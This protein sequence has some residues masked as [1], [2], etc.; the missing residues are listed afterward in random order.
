MPTKADHKFLAA[1]TGSSI[2]FTPVRGAKE[3][4]L[5]AEIYREHLVEPVQ[6]L[7]GQQQAPPRQT[8][9]KSHD[10]F[11]EKWNSCG[12]IDGVE[13]FPKTPIQLSKH[14]KKKYSK[15]REAQLLRKSMLDNGYSSAQW[16]SLKYASS[17]S[18]S[19]DE[20]GESGAE[21]IDEQV[22]LAAQLEARATLTAAGP[23]PLAPAPALGGTPSTYERPTEPEVSRL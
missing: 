22:D 7:A 1:R 17:D 13:I 15:R 5:F 18:D 19:S 8:E 16:K 3:E 2:P 10:G 21:L 9:I 20:S 14:Y 4:R 6:A 23:R 11:A 12:K